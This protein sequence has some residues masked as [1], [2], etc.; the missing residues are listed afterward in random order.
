MAVTVGTVADGSGLS[1]RDRQTA[2]GEM[3]LLAAAE[4]SEL[5]GAL[6]ASL[7]IACQDGTLEHRMCGTAAAGKAVAKTGTLPGTHGLSGYTTTADGHV[8][9]FS[10]LLSGVT[11]DAKARAALDQCVVLLSAARVDS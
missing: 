10:L 2:S 4:S 7:P 11:S 6:R 5:Y 1:G 8:V 9:R 3:S